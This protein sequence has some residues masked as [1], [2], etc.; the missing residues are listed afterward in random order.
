MGRF[1]LW[2]S[3]GNIPSIGWYVPVF[4]SIP[5]QFITKVG[6]ILELT[7]GRCQH[8]WNDICSGNL[9]YNGTLFESDLLTNVIIQCHGHPLATRFYA[10]I[11]RKQLNPAILEVI[12]GFSGYVDSFAQYRDLSQARS[13]NSLSRSHCNHL[14]KLNFSPYLM[15]HELRN[16]PF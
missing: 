12:D 5:I 4:A 9:C 6:Y 13:F 14:C 3:G 16:R 10:F 15:Y 1:W 2:W 11:T 8:G 7:R